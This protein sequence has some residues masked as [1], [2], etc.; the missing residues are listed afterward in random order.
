LEKKE[1]RA[2]ILN[3]RNRMEE[4][5]C[6]SKSMEIINRLVARSDFLN[7]ESIGLYA[8]YGKEV[9]TYPLLDLCVQLGKTV[10]FPRVISKE[11]MEFKAVRSQ[12]DL[13]PG[14]HGIFEPTTKAP[15]PGKIDLLIVPVVAFDS[16]C[17]RIGYGG[18]FYDR[19]LAGHELNTIGV[20]YECQKVDI[21]SV[22]TTDQKLNR[23]ITEDRIYE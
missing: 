10:S 2:K 11:Q 13:Q 18:G 8:S 17:M 12:A 16:N 4:D 14:F 15:V 7:A 22:E 19:Y 6:L 23:I 20:A 9:V 3:I 5:E 1:I 21:I